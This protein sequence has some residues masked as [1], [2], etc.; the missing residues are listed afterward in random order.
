MGDVRNITRIETQGR[1]HSNE[2]L[3]EYSIS[4]GFNGLDY[5]DYREPGGNTKV[6]PAA[7]QGRS[8]WTPIENTYFHFLTIDMG[9]RKMVRKV[10]TAGR[11]TTSECVTEYIV[12]YSDDGELWK[13]VTDSNGEE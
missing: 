6:K 13:S 7:I 10:A 9:E 3:T 2:Y 5:I 12:Q 4:Y 11:A 8:A 1:P